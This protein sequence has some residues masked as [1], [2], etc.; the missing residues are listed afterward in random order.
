MSSYPLFFHLSFQDALTIYVTPPS[1]RISFSV[2][3]VV[4][5]GYDTHRKL[6]VGGD[7]SSFGP[8]KDYLP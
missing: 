1:V 8:K 4:F 6:M 3:R 5:F 2:V 7:A